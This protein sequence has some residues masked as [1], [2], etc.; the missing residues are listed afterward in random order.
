[1]VKNPIFFDHTNKR[2]IR[3]K[4]I[5]S[6]FGSILLFSISIFVVSIFLHPVLPLPGIFHDLSSLHHF[7]K[8]KNP[9]PIVKDPPLH[10]P[11]FIA[12]ESGKILPEKRK[13]YAF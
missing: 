3:A 10:R 8:P 12:T 11:P 2:K 5:F 7:H 1:M 4:K 9:P 6:I 13:V